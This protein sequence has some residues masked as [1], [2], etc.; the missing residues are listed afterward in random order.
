MVAIM[1]APEDSI[2]IL[3]EKPEILDQVR[4]AIL[5]HELL[6]LP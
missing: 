1:N 2:I 6:E 3:R 5:T 4:R